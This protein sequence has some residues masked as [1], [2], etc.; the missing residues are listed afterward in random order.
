MDAIKYLITKGADIYAK[1]TSGLNYLHLACGQPTKLQELLSC[2][3]EDASVKDMLSHR[4]KYCDLFMTVWHCFVE[5]QCYIPDVK[6]L[7]THSGGHGLEIPN[8]G[9]NLPIHYVSTIIRSLRQ[10]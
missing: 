5:S 8:D 9:G 2:L 7:L 6:Y 4:F 1:N 10:C 3:P